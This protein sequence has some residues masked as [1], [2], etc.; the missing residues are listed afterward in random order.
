ML[1]EWLLVEFSN[2]QENSK[3]QRDKLHHQLSRL[4]SENFKR[5]K[6]TL[7]SDEEGLLR[8]FYKLRD[9]EVSSNRE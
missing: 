8:L 3:R 2:Y 1:N 6:E 5:Y 4:E 7:V 9:S